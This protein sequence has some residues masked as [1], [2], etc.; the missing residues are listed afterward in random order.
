MSKNLQISR[1][2]YTP[3]KLTYGNGIWTRI[4]FPIENG[5]IFHCYVSL[6]EGQVVHHYTSFT[7]ARCKL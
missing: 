1:G 7:P 6:P 2:G 5:E 4:V 3:V